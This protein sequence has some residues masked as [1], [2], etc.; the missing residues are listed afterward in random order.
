MNNFIYIITASSEVSSLNLNYYFWLS[1]IR[2]PVRVLRTGEPSQS[3]VSG[4]AFV[5]DETKPDLPLR[6]ASGSL[7]IDLNFY[8]EPRKLLSSA[9]SHETS[10]LPSL[11]TSLTVN[12]ELRATE[13][14]WNLSAPLNQRS[15][16]SPRSTAGWVGQGSRSSRCLISHR[17]RCFVVFASRSLRGAKKHRTAGIWGISVSMRVP[18]RTPLVST[19]RALR[20]A[21]RRA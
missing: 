19:A 7:S 11:P 4:I 1:C 18:A 14:Q 6:E 2:P 16:Q 8:H 13:L 9:P 21:R 12:C 17:G 10:S 15:P 5:D 20:S 3:R